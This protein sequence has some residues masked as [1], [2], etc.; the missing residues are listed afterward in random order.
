MVATVQP[1]TMTGATRTADRLELVAHL[2]GAMSRGTAQGSR[3]PA[4]A[5]AAAILRTAVSLLEEAA[6]DSQVFDKELAARMGAIAPVLGEHISAAREDRLPKISGGARAKRNLAEHNGFGCGPHFMTGSDGDFKRRQRGRGRRPAATATANDIDV[7]VNG[8][9]SHLA[10]SSVPSSEHMDTDKF[11]HDLDSPLSG[12]GCHLGGSQAH[13]GVLQERARV[14]GPR[15]AILELDQ[16]QVPQVSG[17]CPGAV[18]CA[19]PP[20]DGLSDEARAAK[21]KAAV[22]EAA[23]AAIFQKLQDLEASVDASSSRL[24]TAVLASCLH[25]HS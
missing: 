19:V 14:R 1:S 18:A 20:M 23:L 8:K 24:S 11:E 25:P 13:Q 12:D 22:D 15:H 5:M 6:C 21:K 10:S 7:S 16:G 4:A 9:D 17:D 3:Q 2:V